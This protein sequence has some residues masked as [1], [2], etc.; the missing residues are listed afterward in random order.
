MQL[1]AAVALL[2]LLLSACGARDDPCK[3]NWGRV[4]DMS[5]KEMYRYIHWS[6]HSSCSV[7]LDFGGAILFGKTRARYK[8]R[9]GG[10]Y[11][12]MTSPVSAYFDGQKAVCMDPGVVPTAMKCLVYSFGINNEWSFDE[13]MA[14]YGCSVFAFDPAM[15]QPDHQHKANIWFKSI[16]L[17]GQNGVVTRKRFERRPWP[18]KTLDKIYA[19]NVKKG[20]HGS[21]MTIDYL[22][23]DIEFDEWSSIPQWIASGM[24]TRVKQIGLEI[25]FQ[26]YYSI[27]TYREYVSQLQ[28][29]E[30]IGFVRF[31]SRANIYTRPAHIDSLSTTD[32]L[33]FELAFYNRNF[34]K[35]QA[36]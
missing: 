33:N 27:E 28:A 16:G 26:H 36:V 25:H 12:K 29:L 17:S 6:N 9:A 4:E 7:S 20:L 35:P 23:V 22:K 14:E 31:S 11:T 3:G 2:S 18:M 24:L 19:M 15:T 5:G 10:G 32:Y 13:R 34:S 30:D 21:D 1:A 8:K